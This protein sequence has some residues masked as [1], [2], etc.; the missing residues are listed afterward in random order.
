MCR[1]ARGYADHTE[2]DYQ[3]LLVAVAQGVLHT[4]AANDRLTY[5]PNH[6]PDYEI[7]GKRLSWPLS[8]PTTT[9]R[10]SP[11]STTTPVGPISCHNPRHGR[12]R[13]TSR[14]PAQDDPD[15]SYSSRRY[16]G[17]S[18]CRPGADG[19]LPVLRAVG[20]EC[21]DDHRKSCWKVAV[22]LPARG[23]RPV[24]HCTV[25]LPRIDSQVRCG[26]RQRMNRDSLQARSVRYET[27]L[28]RRRDEGRDRGLSSTVHLLFACG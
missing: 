10:P 20:H 5:H 13:S 11:A 3:A 4:E 27:D 18:R 8:A 22:N 2:Y 14:G 7:A 24:R 9:A 6:S 23:Q 17:G 28:G 16:Y 21:G 25:E 1:F 12:S 15:P 26:G 19:S